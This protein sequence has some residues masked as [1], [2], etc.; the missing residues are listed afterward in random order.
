[1]EL[2][3]VIGDVKSGKCYQKVLS[4]EAAKNFLG[5]KIGDQIKGELIDLTGYE[6]QLTGGSDS[7]GFPMRWDV[8]GITRKRIFAVKGVGVTNK[9]GLPN[10]K[11][12]GKRTMRHAGSASIN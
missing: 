8:E 5:K 6:F 9:K 2:K 10:I 12:K 3:L 4:D 1:M 11:K 7:A